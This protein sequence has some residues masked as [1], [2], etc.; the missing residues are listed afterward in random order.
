MRIVKY[1]LKIKLTCNDLWDELGN[2]CSIAGASVN[3]N[4]AELSS[5]EGHSMTS[6]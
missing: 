6:E 1:S 5:K 4:E 2:Q 3:I